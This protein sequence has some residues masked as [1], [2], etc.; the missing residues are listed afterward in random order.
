MG[1]PHKVHRRRYTDKI[2]RPNPNIFYACL[3]AVEGLIFTIYARNDKEIIIRPYQ[4]GD[5]NQEDYY[6]RKSDCRGR[7]NIPSDL[8]QANLKTAP[9]QVRIEGKNSYILTPVEDPTCILCGHSEKDGPLIK[10]SNLFVCYTCL[11]QL[12]C[13]TEELAAQNT[14]SGATET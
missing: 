3:P 4:E 1:T 8:K 14:P 9:L 13:D 12:V 2:L 6:F 11:K 5:E 10:I 7:I